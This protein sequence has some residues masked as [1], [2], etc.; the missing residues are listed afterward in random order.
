MVLVSY[1]GMPVE[2]VNTS[3]KLFMDKVVPAVNEYAAAKNAK[4]SVTA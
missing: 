4:V 3:L 2:K 1:G